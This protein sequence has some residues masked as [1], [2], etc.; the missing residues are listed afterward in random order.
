M[1]ATRLEVRPIGRG[2]VTKTNSASPSALFVFAIPFIAGF[3]RGK[4][5]CCNANK[6]A[7][8]G[9]VPILWKIDRWFRKREALQEL[10][11]KMPSPRLD[12]H[13]RCSIVV[14]IRDETRIATMHIAIELLSNQNS[15]ERDDML[16]LA[17]R[18][19]K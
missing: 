14:Q 6:I 12:S 1:S 5:E 7:R 9:I 11:K 16:A 10:T 8:M 18:R 4:G 17:L 19:F 3:L 13:Q 2:A 15:F